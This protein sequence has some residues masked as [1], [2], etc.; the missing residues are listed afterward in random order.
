MVKFLLLA[1]AFGLAHDH[2]ELEGKW[3]NITIVADN[4]DKIEAEEPLRLYVHEITCTEACSKMEVTFY[5]N[6]N[7]QC[8]KTQ[9]IAYRQ[10]EGNYRVQLNQGDNIL[11]HVHAT[12]ENIVFT[13]E[14]VDRASQKQKQ[15]YLILVVGK[16]GQSLTPKQYENLE[17][18]AE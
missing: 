4:V 11:K 5:V 8:S 14:N 6:T 18:F 2:A 15:K 13:S 1:L 16:N 9:I 3:V 12:P 10:E 7:S 17:E